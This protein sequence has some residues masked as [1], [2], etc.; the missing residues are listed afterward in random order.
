MGIGIG[1]TVLGD[2]ITGT[3]GISWGFTF[4]LLGSYLLQS[5]LIRS[6]RRLNLEMVKELQ[7]G[8]K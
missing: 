1:Q 2:F 3:I 4:V 8:K 7:G 5:E 6:Y